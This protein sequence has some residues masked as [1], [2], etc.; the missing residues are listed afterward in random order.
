MRR[1]LFITS[2]H[3]VEGWPAGFVTVCGPACCFLLMC[4]CCRLHTS[5][6]KM[7]GDDKAA[8]EKLAQDIVMLPTFIRCVCVCVCVCVVT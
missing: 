8:L 1:F 3:L 4:C 5:W 2:S 6:L 7:C